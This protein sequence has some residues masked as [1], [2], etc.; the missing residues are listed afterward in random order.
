MFKVILLK[1]FR[2]VGLGAWPYHFI[3][4]DL[5]HYLKIHTCLSANVKAPFLFLCFAIYLL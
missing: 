1:V 2:Y 3:E 5:V 4:A